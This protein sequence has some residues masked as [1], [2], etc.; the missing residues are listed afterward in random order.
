MTVTVMSFSFKRGS[1]DDSTGNGNAPVAEGDQVGRMSEANEP[2]S[3]RK[4]LCG[5]VFDCRA[6]PNPFWDETLRGD[7]GAT[8]P[9][10][11]SSVRFGHHGTT[12]GSKHDFK[13]AKRR[14]N[15]LKP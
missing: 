3:G 5:C 14:F 15:H 10:A 6:M 11:T 12:R 9:S 8:S 4:S 7:T 1:P 13:D 2:R